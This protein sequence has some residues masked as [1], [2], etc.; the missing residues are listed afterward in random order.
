[1]K[2][3]RF[4]FVDDWQ[5]NIMFM[6][7]SETPVC[8]QIRIVNETIF[9][10]SDTL[11]YLVRA[12]RQ[13]ANLNEVIVPFYHRFLPSCLGLC[14]T[15]TPGGSDMKIEFREYARITA[16]CGVDM[17]SEMKLVHATVM[18]PQQLAELLHQVLDTLLSSKIADFYRA[19][20]PTLTR[21][22]GNIALYETEGKHLEWKQALAA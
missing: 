4:I 16:F 20:R 7:E 12:V 15:K 2:S 8:Y 11:A 6:A 14:I 3:T 22:L 13:G 19:D 9:Q 17:N 5:H 10:C 21:V 18:S 1:M